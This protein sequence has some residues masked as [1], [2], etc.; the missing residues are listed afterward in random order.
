[1]NKETEV[2]KVQ[3]TYS[4]YKNKSKQNISHQFCY[5]SELKAMLNKKS[6]FSAFIQA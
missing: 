5:I 6:E 4:K 1:M 2:L 3:T